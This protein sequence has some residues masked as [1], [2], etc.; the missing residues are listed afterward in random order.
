MKG[1]SW[2]PSVCT[3]SGIGECRGQEGAWRGGIHSAITSRLSCLKTPQICPG[4]AASATGCPAG[5]VARMRHDD[6]NA[7]ALGT[8]A[9]N[10][11]AYRMNK[12]PTT[13]IIAEIA[14]DYLLAIAR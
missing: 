8:E 3:G 2:P 4:C 10:F 14:K 13:R 6:F 7:P 1:R 5:P 9:I 11:T 12:L